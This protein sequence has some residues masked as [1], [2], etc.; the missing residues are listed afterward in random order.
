MTDSAPPPPTLSFIIVKITIRVAYLIQYHVLTFGAICIRVGVV[1]RFRHGEVCIC[2]STREEHEE[3][4]KGWEMAMKW[5]SHGYYE[6]NGDVGAKPQRCC[7]QEGR[8]YRVFI[9][10]VFVLLLATLLGCSWVTSWNLE[11]FGFWMDWNGN[12][13]VDTASLVYVCTQVLVLVCL[14]SPSHASRCCTVIYAKLFCGMSNCVL[15][16]T[17]NLVRFL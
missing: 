2:S 11:T 17:G 12:A 1:C 3:I 10:F 6:V 4:Q 5:L 15:L 14:F 7:M 13:V 8:W 9:A 16:R